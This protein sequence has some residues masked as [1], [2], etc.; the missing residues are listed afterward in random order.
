MFYVYIL[1]LKNGQFY[2][3]FTKDLEIRIKR[4]N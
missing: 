2:T 4:H 1:K 3:G